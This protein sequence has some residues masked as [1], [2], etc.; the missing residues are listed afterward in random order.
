MAVPQSGSADRER[1]LGPGGV[2]F[3]RS[4][5]LTDY[6]R[7]RL[8]QAVGGDTYAG[9]PIS[10]LPE[11]L[12]VYEHLIWDQRP[13]CVLEIGI[14]LGGSG[15]WLRDRLRALAT[16]GG[17]FE[18]AVIGIDIDPGPARENL[19]A[20]DP[21]Y[22]A[23]IT[24]LEGDVRDPELA[25]RVAAEVAGRS[26]LVIEDGAHEYDT[27]LAALDNYAAL[28]PAGGYFVVEDGVVD[29]EALRLLDNWPR[30]VVPA[31][32]EWLASPAGADFEQLREL[33]I[34]A[35]TSHPYGFLRRRG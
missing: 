20:A 18:A 35:I 2:A 8:L 15:L 23:E 12:R 34:Y 25:A 4:M 13:E 29:D 9:V 33:E 31:I 16:Y 6:W 11:D 1:R 14:G 7:A 22:E 32:D 30:G 5:S 27:T 26:C 19:A 28:V 24:I 21:S 17:G 3:D 10:K